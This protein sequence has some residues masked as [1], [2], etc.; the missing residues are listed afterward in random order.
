MKELYNGI[1]AGIL[2]SIGCTVYLQVNNAIGAILFSI[3]LYVICTRGYSLYT[4]KIG[5][6]YQ[7]HTKE[8]IKA[9]LIGLIGNI[10]S[11]TVFGV[12]ISYAIPETKE[13][14]KIICES[15]LANQSAGQTF[16]RA[17]MCGV[18]MYVAVSGYKE[19]KSTLSIFLAVP[20]FILCGFEH[21][22]A[23]VGYFSIA[24][25]LTIDSILFII[26]SIV[27]NS[28]GALLIPSLSTLRNIHEK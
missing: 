25:Y 5:F 6:I 16:L 7:N 18:L 26:I 27:G 10:A 23:N 2:I 13:F 24:N 3:A 19:S 4:G 17:L 1:I 20:V 28:L 9:L 22:I 8:D 11:A 12:L 15:K 14:A 21:S